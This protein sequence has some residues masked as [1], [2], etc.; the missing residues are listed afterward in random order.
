MT[1]KCIFRRRIDLY[2]DAWTKFA[3]NQDGDG[4][5]NIEDSNVEQGLSISVTALKQALQTVAQ[6]HFFIDYLKDETKQLNFQESRE[7][8]TETRQAG[9]SKD[10]KELAKVASNSVRG[11]RSST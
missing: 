5:E 10:F 4:A 9:A 2:T 8:Q 7:R 11:F 1:Y 3:K 6:I